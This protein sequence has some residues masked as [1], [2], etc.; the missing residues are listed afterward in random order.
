MLKVYLADL[1]HTYIALANGAFPLGASYIASFVKKKLGDDVDLRLFK[2]P[3]DLEE[4]LRSETHPDVFMFANYYWNTNLGSAFAKEIKKINRNILVV[5]G[6]PNISKEPDRQKEFL[7]KNSF[8]DFYI[9][10]E[11]EVAV[12]DLLRRYISVNFCI[13]SLKESHVKQSLAIHNGELIVG[14]SIA[15]IGSKN[16]EYKLDDI[17]SPYL[18]GMLD[19]F[20]DNTLAP[21]VQ[22]NRGCPFACTF[23]HEG[24]EY[25]SS[26]S[27]RSVACIKSELE[28][29]AQKMVEKSPDVPRI[30]MAD[31]NFAMF[32]QDIEVTEC[33]AQLQKKYGWP[34]LIRCTTGKNKPE[35]IIEAVEKVERDSLIITSSMQSTNPETLK[36]IKRSN[37]SLDGYKKVQVDIQDKGLRSMADLILGLPLETRETHFNAMFSLIDSGVQE[38]TSFQAMLLKSTELEEQ[39]SVDK[40]GLVGKSRVLPRGI[41]KYKINDKDVI[42]AEI[43][44][45][46][47][48][49]DT[50]SFDD[51]LSSRILHLIAGIYHNSGVF[52]I[53]DYILEKNNI[54]KSKLISVLH[55]RIEDKS[56]SVLKLIE[57]F[58]EA[59]KGELFD[60]EEEC[61]KFYATEENLQ[62]V[63]SSEIG[64]NLLWR[65]IGVSFFRCW[66]DVVEELILS[67]NTLLDIDESIVNDMRTYLLARMLNLEAENIESSIIFE[68]ESNFISEFTGIHS[69]NNC[70]S[71]KIPDTSYDSIEHYISNYGNNPTSWSI[72]L[73]KLRVHLFV[74]K[75]LC[76][77]D[78]NQKVLCGG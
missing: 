25:Y 32:K 22:T 18:N 15:R 76:A 44:T 63:K 75:D 33:F 60:T 40:Y 59:T 9:L 38:F 17:P 24:G 6:G 14:E 5:S 16:S 36:E 68:A 45:I 71:M 30:E 70:F 49:T 41:G 31:S 10:N 39:T 8:I 56:S 54:R 42:I 50:L 1:T 55:N 46:V 64:D 19:Q 67:L 21:F 29:I 34:K 51:Y 37:I 61:L 66:E 58:L 23:C 7:E 35:Q 12:S 72:M 69:D 20:F 13:K 65:Y 28:Y 11:A 52:D 4:K 57:D 77:A 47:V 48:A 78:D 27:M 3:S 73:A 26:V 62:R 74:R 43:E 53:V 2:Y